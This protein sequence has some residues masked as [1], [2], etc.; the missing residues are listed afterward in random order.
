MYNFFI[1]DKF[2]GMLLNREEQFFRMRQ[3]YEAVNAA[4]EHEQLKV[5]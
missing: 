5:N 2:R 4:R 3:D 1:A